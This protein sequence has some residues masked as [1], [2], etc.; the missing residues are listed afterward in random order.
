MVG[1]IALLL[2]WCAGLG[3]ATC[4]AGWKEHAN[5]CYKLSTITGE[6]DHPVCE[7]ERL[8]ARL[9]IV[10]DVPLLTFLEQEL[11][12]DQEYYYVGLRK[13]LGDWF[14]MSD[15]TFDSRMWCGSFPHSCTT[16]KRPHGPGECGAFKGHP[17]AEEGLHNVDCSSQLHHICEYSLECP[18]SWLSIGRSCYITVPRSGNN[19]V[20]I[21]T[22]CEVLPSRFNSDLAVIDNPYTLVAL[23]MVATS[24]RHSFNVGYFKV[25]SQWI[26]SGPFTI[27]FHDVWCGHGQYDKSSCPGQPTDPLHTCAHVAPVASGLFSDNCSLPDAEVLCAVA[28][29][30]VPP[31]PTPP[32]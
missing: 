1:V 6:H 15:E 12:A 26:W 3:L 27:P 24:W 32:P 4:A 17:S 21:E 5:R 19:Q 8:G 16:K 28:S 22:A 31:P 18:D 20:G 10:Q 9:A 11:I 14:I 29:G 7:M 23:W 25:A 2:G 30:T 13:V